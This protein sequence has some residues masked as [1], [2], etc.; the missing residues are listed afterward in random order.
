MARVVAA[1]KKNEKSSVKNYRPTS[2]PS[3]VGKVF[4]KIITE[5]VINFLDEN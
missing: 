1:N 2:L 5:Q 3:V 4:E